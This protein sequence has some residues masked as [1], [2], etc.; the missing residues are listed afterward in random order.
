MKVE[1]TKTHIETDAVNNQATL[2][3]TGVDGEEYCLNNPDNSL[4]KKSDSWYFKKG[5]K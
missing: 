1:I 3:F 4:V 5:K 2:I